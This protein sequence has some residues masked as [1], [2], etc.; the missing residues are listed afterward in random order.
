MNGDP[1]MIKRNVAVLGAVLSLALASPA[2]AQE[3]FAVSGSDIGSGK[4]DYTGKVSVAKTG[5]TWSVQW[6][7]KGEKSIKGTGVIL[8]GCCL[9]VTGTYEGKP[10][11]FLL[12][13]DGAKYVGVWTVDGEQRVG[14]ET[15]IPQ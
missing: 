12:K 13:A 4:D 9:A 10:Y 6:D 11:V 3:S 2:L 1:R 14:K 5:A 7:I 8:E 15:W